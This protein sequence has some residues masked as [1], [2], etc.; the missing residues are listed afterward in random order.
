MFNTKDGKFIQNIFQRD[1]YLEGRT[2]VKADM[3]SKFIQT[4]IFTA[5][6]TP[7]ELDTSVYKF[8]LSYPPEKYAFLPMLDVVQKMEN[9]GYNVWIVT[10][11]NQYFVGAMLKYIQKHLDYTEGVKYDFSKILSPVKNTK[12]PMHIA[13]N[14]LKLLKNGT[15]S[16]AYDDVF[17]KNKKGDLFIVDHLGKV[18]AVENIQRWEGDTALFI[19]GNSDGDFNDTKYIINGNKEAFGIEVNPSSSS[20][21]LKFS[22]AHSNQIVILMPEDFNS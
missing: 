5:G 18:A 15:F 19:G 1:K 9:T 17:T 6:M 2:N 16:L 22:N 10:G 8:L 14:G 11:S 7:G 20:Q 12:I 4:A 3:Y 13:G 21:L